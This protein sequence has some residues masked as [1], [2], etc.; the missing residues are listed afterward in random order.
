MAGFSDDPA[1]DASTDRWMRWGTALIV[2]FVLAF[3]LYRWVEPSNR[4]DA[5]ADQLASL[6]AE[7][8]S[9]YGQNCG[10]CHGAEGEGS[11]GPALNSQQFQTVTSDDQMSQLVAVGVP[12]TSMSAWSQ[13]FGGAFTSQQIRAVVTYVRSW[14]EGAPD[15]PDWRE[16]CP[17][18]GA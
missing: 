1:L 9:L 4:D 18:P 6:G 5:R 13:D 15:R 17:S 16:C 8:Q 7:G 10:S 12:G 2:A 3:P 14:Q 11:T